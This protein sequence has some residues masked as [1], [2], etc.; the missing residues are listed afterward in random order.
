MTP[1]EPHPQLARDCHL[2]GSL[3]G[4]TVLL[5]R[6]ASVPWLILVPAGDERELLGLEPAARA[7]VLDV[8]AQLGEY[9]TRHHDAERINFAAIGNVV[10]QLHLHVVG[11][12]RDDPCWPQPVW[13]HLQPG[14]AYAGDE[15]AA[16]AGR[17]ADELGLTP[18][19]D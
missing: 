8:C 7:R 10:P 6:N 4:S 12:R 14:R 3:Q 13:G 19:H 17:L 16:I 2:L 15:V 11:R 1:V 9:L 5:H 18:A